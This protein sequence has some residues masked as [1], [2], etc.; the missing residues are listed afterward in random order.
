MI[1]KLI[2]INYMQYKMKNKIQKRE[3]PPIIWM[4]DTKFEGPLD[5]N[6]SEMIGNVPTPMVLHTGNMMKQCCDRE[7]TMKDLQIERM[8]DWDVSFYYVWG[9]K[10]RYNKKLEVKNDKRSNI[11]TNCAGLSARKYVKIGNK[12]VLIGVSGFPDAKYKKIG[13]LNQCPELLH[14]FNGEISNIT[15]TIEEIAKNE[16]T[17]LTDKLDYISKNVKINQ[18]LIAVHTC[19]FKEPFVK[20]TEYKE[21]GGY[22]SLYLGESIQMFSEK[23]KEIQIKILCGLPSERDFSMNITQNISIY[24]TKSNKLNYIV[25]EPFNII[26]KHPALNLEKPFCKKVLFL[27]ID[28]V[29]NTSLRHSIDESLKKSATEKTLYNDYGIYSV[30]VALNLV[31]GNWHPEAI[32]VIQRLTKEDPDLKIVVSSHWRMCFLYEELIFIFDIFGL[33]NKIIGT[34]PYC[35]NDRGKEIKSYLEYHPFIENFVIIDDQDN[36]I[37]K[38]YKEHFIKISPHLSLS[39]IPH[40]HEI[41]H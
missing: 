10:D 38:Y 18:L 39:H 4:N 41:L 8:C 40:I 12:T 1:M 21:M 20:L 32:D 14:I 29:L 13:N 2:L 25:V 11:K 34:T 30:R 6:V 19:P 15:Q 31:L 16:A 35:S 9:L 37:S 27:D 3:Y 26:F 23:H 28:G 17:L 7:E 5:I 22:S 33:G 36:G 24:F